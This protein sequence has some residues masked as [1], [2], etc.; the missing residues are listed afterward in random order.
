MARNVGHQDSQPIV[1]EAVEIVDVAP[2]LIGRRVPD[3]Q[4]Q[5]PPRLGRT[6]HQGELD[7]SGQLE[8]ERQL[9]VGRLQQAVALGQL[10]AQVGDPQVSMNP[11]T[12]HAKVVLAL[13]LLD[14]VVGA[15]RQ[16][17]RSCCEPRP[18]WSA[19]RPGSSAAPCRP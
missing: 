19:S 14:I 16:A 5:H 4:P 11:R 1:V 2:E 18:A 13:G 7:F 12:E 10:D 3:R 17:R 9:L 15:G 8:L 6:G